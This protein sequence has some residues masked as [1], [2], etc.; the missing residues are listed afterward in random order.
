MNMKRAIVL[1]SAS[2]AALAITPATASAAVTL[3]GTSCS[4]NDL[5]VV[6][7]SCSGF[8]NGNLVSGNASALADSAAIINGLIGTSYTGGTLPIIETLPSLSGSTINFSTPLYGQTVLAVH[9]GAARGQVNSI[10]YQGTAFYVLEAGALGNGLDT[11][12]F[13]RPGLSNARL[14]VTTPP[15]VPEPG[16]WALLMSGFFGLGLLL[17]RRKAVPKALVSCAD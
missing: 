10:G 8:Y 7:T 16:T 2:M 11:L 17:R 13:N 9:A 6:A 3:G 14:F 12:S 4:L 5:S 15:A 1:A